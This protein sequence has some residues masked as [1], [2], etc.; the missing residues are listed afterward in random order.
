M[1]TLLD[2]FLQCT[3]E[4]QLNI[5]SV[6]VLKKGETIGAWDLTSDTRRPQHSISKSF[7]C[8]AVGLAIDEHKL[9]L[10]T[11]LGEVFP[12]YAHIANVASPALQPSRITVEHLLTM[13]SGHDSPPLWAEERAALVE[14]D[15]VKYY[16]SLPLDR[17]PGT[18]FTYSSGDSFMLSA[19]V[20]ASVGCTIQDYLTPR[21]FDPLGIKHVDWDASPI[22]ITLG[23]AGLRISNEELSRFGQMLL[24]QGMWQG[25]QL[26][27]KEWIEHATSKHI[28]NTGSIDW[29]MGYGYQFWMCSHDAYRADGAHG[30]FCVILPAKEAVIAITSEED[31]M[32]EILNVVWQE[33]L[34]LL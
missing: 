10:D 34:P 2:R 27:P 1:T 11:T 14:K 31:R 12:Q 13:S 33:I 20:Q 28:A 24:Q 18:Q 3:F 7:T 19:L 5:L 25:Q 8:M 26:V 16:M 6:R 21:L 29:S 30:Q 15:W 23:C 9:S 17:A 32:Q 22:G 4:E